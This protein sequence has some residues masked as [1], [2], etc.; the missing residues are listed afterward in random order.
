MQAFP[1]FRFNIQLN[2][3]YWNS[4]SLYWLSK[5][6]LSDSQMTLFITVSPWTLLYVNIIKP[7]IRLAQYSF[8][9]TIKT[10]KQMKI[11]VE[12][13]W[14]PS[15]AFVL[16][17][18]TSKP[19]TPRSEALYKPPASG[20]TRNDPLKKQPLLLKKVIFSAVHLMTYLTTQTWFKT[21]QSPA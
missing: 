14:L 6:V 8:L 15:R 13:H 10:V 19:L 2:I 5:V 11:Y 17:T 18:Q 12:L 7:D 16:T 4:K 20:D 1:I 3:F 21:F 9:L